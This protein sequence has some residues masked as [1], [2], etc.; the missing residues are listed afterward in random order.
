MLIWNATINRR[1][2]LGNNWVEIE[3]CDK[4][5]SGEPSPVRAGV[6]SCVVHCAMLIHPS[7]YG[8]GLTC[9]VLSFCVLTMFKR[10]CKSDDKSSH[11]KSVPKRNHS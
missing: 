5:D 9:E 3:D 7:P 8:T 6:P 2:H 1:F 11:S 4:K 10:E